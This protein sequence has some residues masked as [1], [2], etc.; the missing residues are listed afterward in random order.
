MS[1]SAELAVSHLPRL[2]LQPQ[3]APPA[4]YYAEN[5]LLVVDSVLERY[6]DML[7]A[8]E[9]AFG[10]RIRTLTPAAQR[11]FARLLG[12]KP[13]LRQDALA[14]W[15]VGDEAAHDA[16]VQELAAGGLV[17]RCPQVPLD[18][19]LGLFKL[20]ELRGV[21][22]E[23]APAAKVRKACLVA[24]ITAN[25]GERVGRWRLR[26]CAPWLRLLGGDLL[27]LYRLLFFGDPGKDFTVFVMRDLGV[28]RF[29]AVSLSRQTR[30][31]PNREALEDYLGLLQAQQEVAAVGRCPPSPA[32]SRLAAELLTKLWRPYQNRTLERRRSRTLN[33]LG[34]NLERLGEFDTALACYARSNLPPG[35]E[36]RMRVLHRLGDGD[37][38]EELRGAVLAQPQSALEA[39]FAGRFARPHRRP[40]LPVVDCLLDAPVASIEQHA[41][42][43]LAAD[44]GCGW[45]LENNLPMGL[46][47]L[48]YWSW[49][50]APVEGAFV[51]A[52]QTAP[53][54]LAW[55][56]FFAVR[57]SICEDPLA[58]A[59]RPRLLA[60][61]EAKAGI[62][63]RLFN[64]RRFT[65]QVANAVVRAIPEDHLRRLLAIVREDLAG[66]RSG[67]PD[68]TVIYGPGR[69]EF[70]EVKGP[71]DQLQIHQ[72]LWIQA[73]RKHG[74]P[75]RVMRFRL[76]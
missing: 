11:L 34:R 20:D 13:V 60:T 72:R 44:G 31:F 73:L 54:D 35:R 58:T 46:F 5:L 15:E 55:P 62:A 48:A 29:E 61:V 12:R 42:G 26:R 23:V 8:E 56:D 75:V 47:G 50:F 17:E 49:I 39:D 41:L 52:F 3:Q 16:A 10:Q 18:D 69:Y 32:V 63:N 9:L 57:T 25:V 30:Q 64:W 6:G 45:H 24:R 71:N 38:V 53:V 43:L 37:G 14:Y 2:D 76:S 1:E 33:Q 74:L 68:L 4:H 67:F 59:L 66:K 7:N 70:V 21:F 51:N 22:W 28:H 65:P 40:S 27:A 36:R 19:L